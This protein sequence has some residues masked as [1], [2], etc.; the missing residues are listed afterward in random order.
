MVVEARKVSNEL[1][2]TNHDNNTPETIQQVCQALDALGYEEAAQYVY[3]CDYQ[4][5][6]KAHVK[7]ATEEQMYVYRVLFSNDEVY[8][9][10]M[11]NLT[12]YS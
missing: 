6:K 1:K 4:D 9:V 12:P 10:V 5:W 7:K 3:G 11:M 8:M 2:T